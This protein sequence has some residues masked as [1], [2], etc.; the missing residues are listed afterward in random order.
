MSENLLQA[1]KRERSNFI[2]KS[3]LAGSFDCLLYSQPGEGSVVN[4][5]DTMRSGCRV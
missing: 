1:C 5:E 2:F 3:I 4:N